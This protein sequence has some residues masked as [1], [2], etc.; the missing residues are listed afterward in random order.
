MNVE[1]EIKKLRLLIRMFFGVLIILISG[2]ASIS[3]IGF[4]IATKQ[5]II[6]Y[7]ATLMII[8]LLIGTYEYSKANSELKKIKEYS[9][10]FD[11]KR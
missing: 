2:V 3:I 7:Y 11:A 6:V 8:P 1:V 10:M 9:V 5:P 4:G